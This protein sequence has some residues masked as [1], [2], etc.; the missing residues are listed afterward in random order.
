METGKEEV[1]EKITTV[2]REVD[3]LGEGMKEIKKGQGQLKAEIG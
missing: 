3:K 2:G 1:T